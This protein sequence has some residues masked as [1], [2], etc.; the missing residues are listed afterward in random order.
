[1]FDVETFVHQQTTEADATEYEPIPEDE[2]YAA[3]AAGIQGRTTANGKPL[4]DVSWRIDA[5][6]VPEAHER[7][8]RQTIWLDLTQDGQSLDRGKGRNVQL[9]QLREAIG[10]NKPGEPWSPSMI[11]GAVAKIKISNRINEGKLFIDV[12]QVHPL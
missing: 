3:T 5:P 9:G 7:I 8:G 11:E 2:L 10:Q 6:G 1:M 12:K 4:M